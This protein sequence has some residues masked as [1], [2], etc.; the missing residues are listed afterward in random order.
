MSPIEKNEYEHQIWQINDELKEISKKNAKLEK[1]LI[2]IDKIIK[3]NENNSQKI[4]DEQ[5][6]IKVRMDSFHND[7]RTTNSLNDILNYKTKEAQE[8]ENR[9]ELR[10][11]QIDKKVEM[12]SEDLI[13]EYGRRPHEKSKYKTTISQRKYSKAIYEKNKLLKLNENHPNKEKK[14]EETSRHPNSIAR[15]G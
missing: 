6:H 10:V 15:N 14:Y 8:S 11:Q 4:M 3:N 7:L 1:E 5:N 9:I 12:L 2:K 13:L